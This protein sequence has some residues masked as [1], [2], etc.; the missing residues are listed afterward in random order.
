MFTW[1]S[2]LGFVVLIGASAVSVGATPELMKALGIL[3]PRERIAA[4]EVSL[5]TLQ[6]K[7]FSFKDLKGRVIL[8][9][10]FATWCLP[11]QWEMPE[12]EKLYQAYKTRG[13]VV[14]AIALDR[15][16]APTVE[17]FVKER[18]LTYLVVLDPSMIGAR[19]FGIIG[20]PATF[21]IGRDGFI[22][23]LTYGAKEWDGPEARALIESLL[24]AG[25][26]SKG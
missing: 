24:R 6:R 16:G 7:P 9:N 15:E 5:S 11:C 20:L 2:I 12:M 8:V 21:L 4:P 17:P 23:G 1:A 18:K 10:F 22:K 13:F 25:K 26:D 14:V 3:E 19:Q